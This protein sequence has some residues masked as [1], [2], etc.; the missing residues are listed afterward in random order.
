[1]SK[2]S[3]SIEI[4][5]SLIYRGRRPMKSK[6]T[7]TRFPKGQFPIIVSD[8]H[9]AWTARPSV[10]YGPK[11]LFDAD[12]EAKFLFVRSRFFGTEFDTKILSGTDCYEKKTIFELVRIFKTFFEIRIKL[13]TGPNRL[14]SVRPGV[15]SGFKKKV[16]QVRI[17]TKSSESVS[18]SKI[19]SGPQQSYTSFP[20]DRIL[21]TLTIPQ[22]L[23][24]KRNLKGSYTFK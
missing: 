14:N 24:K 1:M 9:L 6:Q 2:V 3:S 10:Q 4:L 23:F 7:L 21:Y 18:S 13:R 11:I 5:Q 20:N 17:V 8:V 15:G 12:F 22:F 16:Q 19:R